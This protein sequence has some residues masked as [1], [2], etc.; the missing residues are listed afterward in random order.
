[1]NITEFDEAVPVADHQA[2]GA[3][4][5]T[6]QILRQK[7]GLLVQ[8]I[9]DRVASGKA[10]FSCLHPVFAWA[11]VHAGW[12]HNRFVVNAGQTAYER[13]NDRFYT[14]KVAMFGEDVLGYLRVDKAGPKSRHG[15]WLRKD[16]S[17][18]LH[19][20]GTRDGVFLSRSIGR[21]AIPFNLHRLGELENYP[22]EF[23]LA[24][25]GNR[26]V[27]SKRVT[28]PM[29]FGVGAALPPHMDVEAIEVQHW[30][31]HQQE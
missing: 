1:L 5:V 21:N 3:P 18:D 24:A 27:H 11:L 8:Q 20:I 10:I 2:N 19:V 16:Q 22:W 29:A 26:F 31:S 9:E 14:G 15:L 25:L 7:A 13:G 6:V 23:G 17:G 12:L 28:Q 30:V 4:E